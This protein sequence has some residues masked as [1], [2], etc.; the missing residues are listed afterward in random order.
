MQP[1]VFIPFEN[2]MPSDYIN[3]HAYEGF[4]QLNWVIIPLDVESLWEDDFKIPA[5]AVVVGNAGVIRRALEIQAIPF[6]LAI[7]IPPCLNKLDYLGRT[8]QTGRMMSLRMGFSRPVFIKPL[9][10]F[11]LFTGQ[12][13]HSP[14]DL[15]QL[16]HIGDQELLL[17][18]DAVEWVSEFRVFVSQDKVIHIAHYDG[19]IWAS[20]N[21]EQLFQFISTYEKHGSPSAYTIDVGLL[22]TGKT[23]LVEVNDGFSVAPYS[24]PHDLYG[25]FLA[26][27][28]K[29]IVDSSHCQ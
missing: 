2:G 9:Y 29:E 15:Q 10:Q 21:R 23:T 19:D 13:V 3:Y 28:Y 16:A 20:P 11:K 27:R 5:D 7:N 26:T 18:S 8:V 17:I 25:E 1:K 22:S 12:I 6:P 14:D 24:M 4:K